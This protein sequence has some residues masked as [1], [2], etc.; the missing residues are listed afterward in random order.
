MG[1]LF[2][3]EFGLASRRRLAAPRS[4]A[5]GTRTHQ[6]VTHGPVGTTKRRSTSLLLPA[7][8]GEFPGPEPSAFAP[9]GWACVNALL[10]AAEPAS[11][12]PPSLA[13]YSRIS[14]AHPSLFCCLVEK[15]LNV[16]YCCR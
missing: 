1:P 3:A 12:A 10:H 13:A 11:R 5:V 14:S 8:V 15:L 9:I 4:L 16:N 6:P 2:R 7:V